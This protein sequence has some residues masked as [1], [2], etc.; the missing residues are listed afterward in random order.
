MCFTG[1]PGGCDYIWVYEARDHPGGSTDSLTSEELERQPLVQ[2]Q[3]VS[4]DDPIVSPL[5]LYWVRTV[6]FIIRVMW[7]TNVVL[8]FILLLSDFV[9]IPGLNNRGRSFLEIDLVILSGLTNLLTYWCFT[10]PAYYERVLGYVTAGLLGVD[11]LVMFSVT[12]LRHQFG[13]IG[14]FLMLWTLAT[15]LFNCYADYTVERAKVYQE[16]RYTGRPENRKTFFEAIV[17]SFKF[18]IKLVLF[19]IIWNISL[20]LWLMAFDT[21]EKPPGKMVAV[22]NDQFKLHLSCYGDMTNGSQP[23]VLVEG[24]QTTSS[25][26][27]Q[28]WIEEL[29][30]LNKLERYCFY[31]RPGYGFSDSAAS[32]VSVSI[33]VDYLEEALKQSGVPGP[34]ALVGFDVGGLYSRAFAS[35]NPTITKSIMLVDSWHEDM[36]KL[37]PFPKKET[38]SFPELSLM[39]T[40]VG[41]KL[42]FQGI[43]S[44]LG[45]VTNLHWFTHPKKYSSKARIYGPDMVHQSQYIRARLQEQITA[46]ILSYNEVAGSHLQDIPL[47]VVSSDYMIKR[48]K[49]WGNWQRQLAKLSTDTEEWTVVEKTNHFMWESKSGKSALQEALLRMLGA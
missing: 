30:D 28:E 10:V 25:E 6:K 7:I 12:Y 21:H 32:P 37:K 18:L 38:Y 17:I 16:I 35:K 1:Q 27:F 26:E 9:A 19:V 36:L 20:N 34:F 31:D 29:Y 15:V 49:N 8:F 11:F 46:S 40:G 2:G 33:I 13:F 4:P 24:G 45:V 47:Y 39:T 23:I 3:F 22:N 5:N 41:F 44:P 43:V 42:W 48:S 14:N